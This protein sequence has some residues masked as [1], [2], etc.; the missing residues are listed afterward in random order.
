ML[1][2]SPM[3]CILVGMVLGYLCG[4]QTRFFGWKSTAGLLL[5]IAIA[6]AYSYTS[7][8]PF[9]AYLLSVMYIGGYIALIVGVLLG[10]V[11]GKK[12]GRLTSLVVR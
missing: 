12:S 1:L 8:E 3:F 4:Y 7:N 9:I 2:L 6:V 11:I 5:P 10:A